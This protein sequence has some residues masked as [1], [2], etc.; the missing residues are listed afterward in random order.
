MPARGVGLRFLSCILPG[1]RFLGVLAALLPWTPGV[2]AQA[3]PTSRPAAY[4]VARD[5]LQ[6]DDFQRTVRRAGLIFDGTVIAIRC[7]VGKGKLPKT[8]RVSFQVKQ[9]VREARSGSSYAIREWAGLWTAGGEPRYRVG[10]RAL[11]F[12]YA[13]GR[14]TWIWAYNLSRG[15]CI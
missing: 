15:G 1:V 10:E 11:L 13:P 4:D 2:V 3:A 14:T 6:R 12:L 8:Y 7:E 5:G 9:G